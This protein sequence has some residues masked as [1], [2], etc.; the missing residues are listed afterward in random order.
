MGTDDD[1]PR[2]AHICDT[3]TGIPN[4]SSA[5]GSTALPCHGDHKLS[6]LVSH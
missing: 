4:K 6:S 3:D 1:S 5:V 2:E